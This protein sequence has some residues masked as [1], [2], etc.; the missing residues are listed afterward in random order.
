M[1]PSTI[2]DERQRQGT[3]LRHRCKRS[4]AFAVGA[5]AAVTTKMGRKASQISLRGLPVFDCERQSQFRLK[6]RQR[7]DERHYLSCLNFRR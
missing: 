5:S 2:I 7:D 6:S 1:T 4:L 3:G